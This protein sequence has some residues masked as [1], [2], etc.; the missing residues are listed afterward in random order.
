MKYAEVVSDPQSQWTAGWYLTAAANGG[1][2]GAA[3]SSGK[4]QSGYD[5]VQ[6]VTFFTN[7]T[8]S[9]DDLAL[10]S[11]I[12]ANEYYIVATNTADGKDGQVLKYDETTKSV[13]LVPY[14]VAANLYGNAY[15]ACLWKVSST[16]ANNVITYTFESRLAKGNPRAAENFD[17]GKHYLRPVSYNFLSQIDNA[18]EYGTNGY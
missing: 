6:F 10:V 1:L 4:P 11:S 13:S 16:T 8:F 9:A 7:K 18:A 3:Y 15:D 5:R 14:S 12:D 17:P 2:Q